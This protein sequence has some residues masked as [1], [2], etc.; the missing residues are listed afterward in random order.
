MV[1]STSARSVALKLGQVA[2]GGAR[3]QWA[4]PGPGIPRGEGEY[5]FVAP[6]NGLLT[7]VIEQH[8]YIE[9]YE[10]TSPQVIPTS[11]VFFDCGLVVELA[12][13]VERPSGCQVA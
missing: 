6:N 5:I 4:G 11:R 10:V 12:E 7:T 9:A 1:P 8:G 2:K 3:G 13:H